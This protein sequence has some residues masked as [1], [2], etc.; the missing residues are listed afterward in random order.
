MIK[1]RYA[2]MGYGGG[3]MMIPMILLTIILIIAL[4]YI[5]TRLCK[6]GHINGSSEDTTSKALE[7]L[8]NRYANGE[9]TDEEYKNKKELLLK[10]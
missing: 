10:K 6:K 4:V 1:M 8:N 9:L 3:F 2:H 5:V 7:T